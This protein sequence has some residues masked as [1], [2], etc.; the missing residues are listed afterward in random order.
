VDVAKSQ[1]LVTWGFRVPS[2]LQRVRS[3]SYRSV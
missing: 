1:F 2:M 3:I